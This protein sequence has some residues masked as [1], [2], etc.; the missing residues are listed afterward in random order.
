MKQRTQEQELFESIRKEVMKQQNG[1]I[2]YS[3]SEINSVEIIKK[4]ATKIANSEASPVE[5]PIIP[6]EK[7]YYKID[8]YDNCIEPCLVNS[9][10]HIGCVACDNCENCIRREYVKGFI[11]CKEIDK[12]T[13]K[14]Q[15]V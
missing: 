7:Y 9:G 2:D 10:L 1:A 5:R 12:A 3:E 15:A 6:P 13:G 8:N 11:I 14:T 4:F